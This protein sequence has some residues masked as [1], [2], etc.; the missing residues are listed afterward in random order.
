M[1]GFQLYATVGIVAAVLAAAVHYV[2]VARRRPRAPRGPRTVRRYNL[3]QRLVHLA[4]T[5]SFLA[6]AATGFYASI[7]WG[8]PMSGYLLMVH[9]I[10]GAVFAVSVAAM[11]VTW[12]ASHAFA[13]PDGQ[14]LR[15]GGCL[16]AAGDLPAGRFDAGDKVYFW[17]AAALGLTT[18]LS[19]LLSMTS[20]F[21]TTGQ[22][23]LYDVHR[24]SALVLVIATI[25]HA[26]A[27]TLAKPGAL[28][29]LLSGR[30][31]RAWA[32]RYHPLWNPTSDPP[33]K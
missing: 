15:R 5:L 4:L 31:S 11:L 17:L 19:M 27:T 3:W 24:W 1:S 28:G 14:W 9:T 12:A 10:F 8:G 30:V 7:G 21:G 22:A 6:L 29:A 20:L 33:S 23:L 26:Y 32:E 13:P 18:L 16:S 2:L 25:W